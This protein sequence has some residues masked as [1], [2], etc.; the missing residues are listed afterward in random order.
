MLSESTV[1]FGT[2]L[3]LSRR[4]LFATALAGDNRVVN[5]GELV[6]P[7]DGVRKWKEPSF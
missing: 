1:P 5:L 7:C 4:A 2:D 6:E 3:D